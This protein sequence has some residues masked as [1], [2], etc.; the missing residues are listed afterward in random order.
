MKKIYLTL[1]LVGG[2]AM[3]VLA[4][5]PL[6]KGGKQFNIG[7]GFSRWGLP[8][9][10]GLDFGIHKDITLGFQFEYQSY[11]E[12]WNGKKWGHKIYSFGGNLNYHF[13]TLLEIPRDW[14]FYA[15]INIGFLVWNSPSGYG[16]SHKSGLGLGAQIGGRYYFTNSTGI[17]LELGGGNVVSGGRIGLSFKL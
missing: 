15:G 5:S 10:A 1:I 2:L 8:I 4:Q 17:H 16:G 6:G 7:A 9:Y 14:D 11:N 13:N 3:S 12:D